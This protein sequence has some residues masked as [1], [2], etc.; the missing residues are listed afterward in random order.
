MPIR[1][2]G[3]AHPRN[4]DGGDPANQAQPETS[5]TK[6]HNSRAQSTAKDE[7]GATQAG[8][9]SKAVASGSAAT[10]NHN[11]VPAASRLIFA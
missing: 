11:I 9:A 10:H 8:V 6:T 1:T 3:K 5:A 7:I 2:L 4:K